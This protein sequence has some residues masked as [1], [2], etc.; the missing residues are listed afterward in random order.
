MARILISMEEVKMIMEDFRMG[1]I[2][3]TIAMLIIMQIIT[4]IT[5]K[6]NFMRIKIE[7]IA[8]APTLLPT[9][10]TATPTTNLH[11]TLSKIVIYF[12]IL[13]IKEII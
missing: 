4:I 12:L 2:T 6:E 1:E 8:Q 10:T 11:R 9:A 5:I 7:T 13:K 3:T